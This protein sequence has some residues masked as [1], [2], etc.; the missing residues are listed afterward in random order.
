MGIILDI[1]KLRKITPFHKIT[2][3]ME[4]NELWFK[5][6]DGKSIEENEYFEK[7]IPA[8]REAIG[9]ENISET[10]TE[11]TGYHFGIFL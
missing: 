5:G 3:D 11:E 2:F 9:N 8:L 1:T 10:F 4:R 7:T 6:M